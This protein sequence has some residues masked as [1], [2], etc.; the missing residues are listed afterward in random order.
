MKHL[1]DF[2]AATVALFLLFSWINGIAPLTL[3]PTQTSCSKSFGIF[4][5]QRLEVRKVI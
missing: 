5:S 2:G 3:Y 1:I 4:R